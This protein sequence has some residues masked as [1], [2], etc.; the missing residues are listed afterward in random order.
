MDIQALNE[1]YRNKTPQEIIAKALELADGEIIVSTNF[2]P[3]EAV[4]LHMCTTLKPDM[5]TIWADSGYMMEET[6][7]FAEKAIQSLKLNIKVYNPLMT[8]ARRDAIYGAV[9]GLESEEEVE[10]FSEM[11]KL[12]PFRRALDETKPKV[13]FTSLRKEQNAFRDT[14]DVFVKDGNGPLKVNPVFY[15]SEAQME[16]YISQHNLPDEKIYFD[17][18]KINEKRECGLHKPSF[19]K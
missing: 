14:L 4:I 1:E 18:T 9:P 8:A 13:W 11:V 7:R 3:L 19:S 12:E 2:R 5:T 17:P 15:W 10:A 16:E 6:Y